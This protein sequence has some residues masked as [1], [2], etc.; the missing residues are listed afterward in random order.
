MSI[1]ITFKGSAI[2]ING[3]LPVA[4]N[5]APDFTVTKMDLS[6]LHLKDLLGKK[7]LLNIF[8][9]IDTSVCAQSVR[10]FNQKAAD[11]NNTVVLCISADLP[12]A[13]ARFCGTEGL[14]NVMPAS[15]FR[16]PEFANA[17]GIRIT[18][19]PLAGLLARTVVVIDAKGHIA[20]TEQVP[21][22]THEPNYEAALSALSRC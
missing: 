16:H 7:V 17:Y 11:L 20:Y 14:T 4:G 22:I 8:P 2:R 15:I 3:T 6:E 12:F 9:S 10:S 21:E 1:K 19:G 5:T 18:D 13:Q